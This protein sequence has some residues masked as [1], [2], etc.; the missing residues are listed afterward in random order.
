M[1]VASLRD[2]N[3]WRAT[4]ENTS[5]LPPEA[6]VLDASVFQELL[7]SLA[8]DLDIVVSIY[9]TF[10]CTAATL[11]GSLPQQDCAAQAAT[12]HTLKGSASMVGAVR[13]ARLAAHLQQ[14]AAKSVH[15]VIKTRIEELTGEL[16]IFRTAVSAY[17][18]S[19]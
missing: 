18:R 11:I 7:E 16:D 10:L 13:I 12:L 17:V 8:G 6:L 15:P 4:T 19:R 1:M 3:G 2:P 5:A 9:R 14:V